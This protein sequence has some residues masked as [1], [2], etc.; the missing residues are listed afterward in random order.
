MK[1]DS[2]IFLLLICVGVLTI[3]I[4]ALVS[5]PIEYKRCYTQ[6]E[7]TYKAALKM[8]KTVC[9]V[10]NQVSS[11]LERNCKDKFHHD[12]SISP[13]L[14][15]IKCAS[16]VFNLFQKFKDSYEFMDE[17]FGAGLKL[18]YVLAF[19]MLFAKIYNSL[20]SFTIWAKKTN[21]NRNIR[22]SN[23]FLMQTLP[24]SNSDMEHIRNQLQV[25]D[26]KD[27]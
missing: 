27:D 8:K 1:L 11:I 17:N 4:P 19:L 24:D 18:T 12:L 23:N 10:P 22:K 20:R 9:D 16:D 14:E 26:M 15:G 5:L 7:I 2:K 25:A 13:R 3:V 6:A 21:L